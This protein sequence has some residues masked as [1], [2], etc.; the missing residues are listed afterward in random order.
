MFSSLL[1]LWGKSAYPISDAYTLGNHLV[2]LSVA[3]KQRQPFP[4]IVGGPILEQWNEFA[5]KFPNGKTVKL[6]HGSLP[7]CSMA[8]G[9]FLFKNSPKVVAIDVGLEYLDSEAAMW[10][11]KHEFAH[12][13]HNDSLKQFVP[14][15][16]TSVTASF[17]CT[18]WYSPLL[19]GWATHIV[20]EKTF[21]LK[22]E[23]NAD[24]LALENATE[25]E[26]KGA[27]RFFEATIQAANEL[28]PLNSFSNRAKKFIGELFDR[29]P[30]HSARM[31]K[32]ETLLKSRFNY[33]QAM[34]GDTKKD[35]RV[36]KLK[37]YTIFRATTPVT[38]PKYKDKV[39]EVLHRLGVE[40]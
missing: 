7:H 30:C 24:N 23:I 13:N 20:A 14:L 29:H 40:N 15:L 34:L 17:F 3:E 12:I 28:C 19:I 31:G 32:A 33:S 27:V 25:E 8:L 35:D 39:V 11:A 21:G 10:F 2:P 6:V 9:T 26:L 16:V 4:A 1:S 37:E 38:D 5:S 18:V 22:A 36:R